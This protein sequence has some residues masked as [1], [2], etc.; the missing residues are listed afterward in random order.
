MRSRSHVHA[1]KRCYAL[2]RMMPVFVTRVVFLWPLPS[3]TSYIVAGAGVCSFAFLHFRTSVEQLLSFSSADLHAARSLCCTLCLHV[4]VPVVPVCQTI[5]GLGLC[6]L[7]K[8]CVQLRIACGGYSSCG[9]AAC[10]SAGAIPGKDGRCIPLVSEHASKSLL[11][12]MQQHCF[13]TRHGALLLR[14]CAVAVPN[15]TTAHGSICIR[16]AHALGLGRMVSGWACV[17]LVLTS[18]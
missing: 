7:R 9:G 3:V 14:L 18:R 16:A 2:Q 8:K 13:C 10:V 15:T 11:M 17:V 1:P 5:A 4:A 12:A 6:L